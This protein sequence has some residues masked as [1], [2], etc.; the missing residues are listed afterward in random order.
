MNYYLITFKGDPN[1]AFPGGGTK[2]VEAEN[3][4]LA[5]EQIDS[6]WNIE[7][8]KAISNPET[9]YTVLKNHLHNTLGLTKED[10]RA[11]V[12]EAIE[13]IVE[14][15]MDV[16][17]D[18]G[19]SI[20]RIVDSAV[21]EKSWRGALW[22]DAKNLDEVIQD[23][24]AKEISK[25]LMKQIGVDVKVKRRTPM[26]LGACACEVCSGYCG[27]GIKGHHV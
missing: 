12:N 21:R 17:L 14:R 10:V 9:N 3:P 2:V 25:G 23:K 13:S 15:R 20:K 4:K 18:G 8:I 7:S 26:S 19:E 24:I 6:Q 16:S 27:C 5:S 1:L 11:M 22:S